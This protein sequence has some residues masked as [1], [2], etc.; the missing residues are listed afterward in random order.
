MSTKYKVHLQN[1][2]NVTDVPNRFSI[3]RWVNEVLADERDHA[4]LTIRIVDEDE[5]QRLNRDYRGKDK[6]TNVLSFG[7]E[8]P[9]EVDEALLGDL[10]ICAQVVTREASEQ[11]KTQEA[12]WAHM[13]VHGILHL[14]GYDHENDADAE[15][16][17]SKEIA[18]LAR[19]DFPN[20]YTELEGGPT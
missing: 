6:P 11:D 5:S 8:L 1:V 19:L 20:P 15:V 14:L 12:H 16:M 4:E 3:Q 13:I 7:F 9:D 2:S 17:E 18:I 10:I